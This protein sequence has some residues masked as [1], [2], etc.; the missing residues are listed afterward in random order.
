MKHL[1]FA[2]FSLISVLGTAQ[3]YNK[4]SAGFNIGG[5]DG[6]HNT[7]HTTHIYQFTHYELN[8]RYMFNNRIGLKFDAG[9]DHFNFTPN[10]FT[11]QTASTR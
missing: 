7:N 2:F 1:L 9:F 11:C 3:D 10:N 6:M 8:S 4:W 5:H